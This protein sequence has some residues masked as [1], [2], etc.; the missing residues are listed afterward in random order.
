MDLDELAGRLDASADRVGPE[1][2]RTVQQQARLLRALIRENASGRP[3]PNIITGQYFDS[4]RSE[5][6][7]VPEGGGATVGTNRPQGRRLE[8]GFVG[9]DSIGR[10]YCVDMETEALSRSG[11]VTHEQLEE[12]QEVL[13]LNPETRLS[14][15][16][17]VTHIYRSTGMHDL[18]RMESTTFS[19]LTTPDHRW[20]VQRYYGRKKVWLSDTRTTEQLANNHRITRAAPCANLPTSSPHSDALVELA[21]WFWTEGSYDWGRKDGKPLVGVR[22]IGIR[23]S[24]SPVVNPGNVESIRRCLYTL[25]GE[26]GGFSEGAHWKEA[27]NRWTKVITFR[28]DR[29]GAWLLENIVSRPEKI[30]APEFLTSLTERQLQ[31]F[32]DT[33]MKADGFL[34]QTE[35]P[36]MGQ[37]SLNRLRSFEI[38]CALLGQPT[39]TRVHSRKTGMWV[40][41][42]LKKSTCNPKANA[43]RTDGKAWRSVYESV[44]ERTTIWCPTTPNGTWLARRRG[45]VYF[46]GNS[47]PPF[48]HVAPAVNELSPEY[49]RAFHAA[50][51]RIFGG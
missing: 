1:I 40:T 29:V 38:A 36:V 42:L 25:F 10:H 2:N 12:G 7:H 39:T 50:C 21:G 43:T 11:W 9:T 35:V 19:S 33:S 15:W 5:P 4:W 51:D 23:I 48:P 26:P 34:S 8:Y 14:E 45:T 6:F 3:G 32:I 28:V 13:T 18:V 41:S 30:I 24:Q 49:E 16:Q 27:Q 31:I 22:A 47:Q 37:K 17:P 44:Q 20:P 46:T